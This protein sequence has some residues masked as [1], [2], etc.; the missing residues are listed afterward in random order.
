MKFTIERDALHRAVKLARIAVPTK[1]TSLPILTHFVLT[2]TP[3]GGLL[4]EATDMEIVAAAEC[5]AVVEQPGSATAPATMLASM[6][7]QCPAPRLSVALDKGKLR[8]AG[9]GAKL[10]LPSLH[11]EDWPDWTGKGTVT[12]FAECDAAALRD[13]VGRVAVAAANEP[14]RVLD[15]I[16]LEF[17]D[18]EL[19]LSA[20]DG[21]RC[22][23]TTIAV[24]RPGGE[25]ARAAAIVPGGALRE[26]VGALPDGTIAI[27]RRGNVVC[28]TGATARARSRTIEGAFP[29]LLGIVRIDATTEVRLPRAEL[30]D[31]TRLAMLA[32]FAGKADGKG[33][34]IVRVDLAIGPDGCA[35]RGAD[36]AEAEVRVPLAGDTPASPFAVS[37]DGHKLAEALQSI[38]GESVVMRARS[39]TQVIVFAPGDEGAGETLHGIMPMHVGGQ[40]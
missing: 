29:N 37:L 10:A 26:I 27:E 12:P 11:A 19:R 14:G 38:P 8:L 28:F 20:A 33:R 23:T 2:A 1:P 21:F 9:E 34:A 17:G 30:R 7:A 25:T 18:G 6:L 35:V 13:A 5:P 3:D 31:A 15:G 24:A 39:A 22:A 36:D 32:A 40:G 16:H 4:V